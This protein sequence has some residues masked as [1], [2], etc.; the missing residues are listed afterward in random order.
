M[1]GQEARLLGHGGVRAVALAAGPA[2]PRSAAACSIWRPAVIFCRAG[3]SGGL[4]RTGIRSWRWRC[5]PWWS[6]ASVMIRW[7]RCAGRSSRCAHWPGSC[8]P[9]RR[10]RISRA[11]GSGA[12]PVAATRGECS[13]RAVAWR[14]D[15]ADV[16]EVSIAACDFRPGG[17][18]PK[19][20]CALARAARLVGD[21]V[22]MSQVTAAVI[23][24]MAAGAASRPGAAPGGRLSV[25]GGRLGRRHPTG[26]RP[27]AAVG[28]TRPRWRARPVRSGGRGAAR[29]TA[30]RA[31]ERG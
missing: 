4:L 26:L 31:R 13:A 30:A 2:P 10:R 6:R 14:L 24:G 25:T 8:G 7:R 11:G 27:A 5:C 3:V 19:P 17:Y 22:L 15:Q 28:C 9:R 12:C 23:A 18:S 1:S 20:L 16:G 29:M 21:D